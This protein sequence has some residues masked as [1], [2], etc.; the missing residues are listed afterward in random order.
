MNMD[1]RNSG[2]KR[3]TL[4]NLIVKEKSCRLFDFHFVSKSIGTCPPNVT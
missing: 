1:C 4:E 3:F 2:R